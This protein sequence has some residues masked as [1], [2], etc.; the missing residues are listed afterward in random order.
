[1]VA[2]KQ[3]KL[4]FKQLLA[5]KDEIEQQL[6]FALEWL[7]LPD[8]HQCRIVSWRNDSPLQDDAR[9]DE[10]A[11]WMADRIIRMDAAFRPLVRALP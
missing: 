1:M 8:A 9:W 6:G 3:P 2:G 10:F 5:R 7:E 11:E 4:H